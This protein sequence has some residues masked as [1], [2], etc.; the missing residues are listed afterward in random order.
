MSRR[1]IPRGPKTEINQLAY[2]CHRLLNQFEDSQ[3]VFDENAVVADL[4][5]LATECCRLLENPSTE[6]VEKTTL[7][8]IVNLIKNFSVYVNDTMR[9]AC[10]K[11]GAVLIKKYSTGILLEEC[12][13]YILSELALGFSKFSC[14]Q[15]DFDSVTQIASEVIARLVND[16]YEQDGLRTF[17]FHFC[18]LLVNSFSKWLVKDNVGDPLKS[19]ISYLAGRFISMSSMKDKT[20]KNLANLVKMFSDWYIL[21]NRIIN[22]KE[23]VLCISEKFIQMYETDR[24]KYV[25][26]LSLSSL[27]NHLSTWYKEEENE[28]LRKVALAIAEKIG[29]HTNVFRMKFYQARSLSGLAVNLSKWLEK[30][31]E[32]KVI[33]RALL[34]ILQA[35]GRHF[36][37]NKY[38]ETYTFEQLSF[39][40]IAICRL[41]EEGGT[42][43]VKEG[44][45]VLAKVIIERHE[46]NH[47]TYSNLAE[48]SYFAK[49]LS[50][51]Q[52]EIDGELRNVASKATLALAKSFRSK[53]FRNE[54]ANYFLEF[55]FSNLAHSF[56]S[57]YDYDDEIQS[58]NCAMEIIGFII[59]KSY[60]ENVFSFFYENE[61]CLLVAAFSKWSGDSQSIRQASLDMAYIIVGSFYYELENF[62][63]RNLS[64]LALAFSK[65]C[66]NDQKQIFEQS[67]Q[68]IA[69]TVTEIYKGNK[70]ENFD[71][72]DI[73]NL[74]SAFMKFYGID[75][76][77]RSLR[78]AILDIS[79][80]VAVNIS[81]EE[82]VERYSS[83]S[84][85]QI[86]AHAF[87][88]WSGCDNDSVDVE[89][90]TGTVDDENTLKVAMLAI[91]NVVSKHY[92]ENCLKDYSLFEVCILSKAFAKWFKEEDIFGTTKLIARYI[93]NHCEDSLNVCS[94]QCLSFLLKSFSSWHYKS[95]PGVD[96]KKAVE[97]IA[98]IVISR[99][100]EHNR[101]QV[102][103]TSEL[104]NF[105]IL[106]SKWYE[107]DTEKII[108][109]SIEVIAKRI[110]VKYK[111]D[112]LAGCRTKDLAKLARGFGFWSDEPVIEECIV[113]IARK[114]LDLEITL[115]AIKS[116]YL[117]Y[118]AISFSKFLSNH[119]DSSS[120]ETLTK[121]TA[122]AI[123]AHIPSYFKF[124]NFPYLSGLMKTFIE[125]SDE[126]LFK[127]AV[128]SIKKMIDANEEQQLALVVSTT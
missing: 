77:D 54:T 109:K 40:A 29:K 83:P 27:C 101:P 72:S 87:S 47:L 85:L 32:E 113:Y 92:H 5:V 49:A 119:Y 18:F 4:V 84:Y 128:V 107:N 33:R 95:D 91:A 24:M 55:D 59:H 52:N 105:A 103:S 9:V 7:I 93:L 38:L 69:R 102:Y 16:R 68:T 65:W 116:K 64:Q 76:E 121:A 51:W 108:F 74:T 44:T 46:G 31:N 111:S 11:L 12:T 35:V 86:L 73:I 104:A 42:N 94:A 37:R 75:N 120:I 112:E 53:Y 57:W 39:I 126:Q 127:D 114:V 117:V 56:A 25:D 124:Y 23:V 22:L 106:L 19:A 81:N 8:S 123:N 78:N 17:P 21:D 125:F 97:V 2:K 1:H 10:Y 30:D 71:A 96:V 99:L 118:F 26:P 79:K 3:D 100:A 89:E 43:E 67:V 98:I 90:S 61:L 80:T 63:P 41:I 13:P 50:Y 20:G 48:M 6:D 60:T 122:V 28:T 70:L 14:D 58:L 36:R 66:D 15:E 115:L 34:H 45:K 62:S 82:K 110:I 88:K